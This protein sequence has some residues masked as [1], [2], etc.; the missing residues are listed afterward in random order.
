[1]E[2]FTEVSFDSS[3]ERRKYD[4]GHCGIVASTRRFEKVGEQSMHIHV[5]DI[6]RGMGRLA[7]IDT[8]EKS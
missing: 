8:T 6:R 1:M 5:P 4:Q 7:G 2:T 3:F